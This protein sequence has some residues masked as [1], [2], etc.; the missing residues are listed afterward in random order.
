MEVRRLSGKRERVSGKM[1]GER[2]E[3]GGVGR[4]GIQ[5]TVR[6]GKRMKDGQDNSSNTILSQLKCGHRTSSHTR[7]QNYADSDTKMKALATSTLSVRFETVDVPL[8]HGRLLNGSADV[9]ETSPTFAVGHASRPCQTV[10][11]ANTQQSVF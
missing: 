10:N 5:V 9:P 8:F 7:Q 2:G 6:C 1:G 3:G 4:K 11:T